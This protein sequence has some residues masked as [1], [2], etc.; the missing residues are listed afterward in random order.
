MDPPLPLL[1]RGAEEA[2]DFRS[3]VPAG[4]RGLGEWAGSAVWVAAEKLDG[5]LRG[6]PRSSAG[7]IGQMVEGAP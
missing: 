7:L 6:V 4:I 2:A 1:E 3:V 5:A